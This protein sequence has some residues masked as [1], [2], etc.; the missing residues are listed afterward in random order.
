MPSKRHVF[1]DTSA[2]V[3]HYHDEKG[4]QAVN[5]LWEDEH[6]RLFISRLS[7]LEF[8]SAFAAK[9]RAYEVDLEQFTVV[10]N[11]FLA[12]LGDGRPR[13]VSLTDS[14]YQLAERLLREHA[15]EAPLR[16]LDAL[17]LASAMLLHKG[18][19]L[20]AFVA[21]DRQLIRLATDNNLPALNPE[22]ES[23]RGS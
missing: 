23:T 12:D 5:R 2:L 10:R 3:K 19:P 4:S 21:A 16:T 9:H 20:D 7:V 1:L 6:A 17:H 8:V 15:P 22:R 18:S 14:H 13:A 11:R